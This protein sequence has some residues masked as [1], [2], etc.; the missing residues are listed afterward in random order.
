MIHIQDKAIRTMEELLEQ[1]E[2]FISMLTAQL[3]QTT[4]LART[5]AQ[6]LDSRS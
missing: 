6:E 4:E 2:E 5:M 3:E 1:K